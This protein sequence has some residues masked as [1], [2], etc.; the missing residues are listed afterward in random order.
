MK[1]SIE[2]LT[3]L[4]E[5]YCELEEVLN[6]KEFIEILDKDLMDK[7]SN[8]LIENNMLIHDNIN[9][10]YLCDL[11][12]QFNNDIGKHI[13]TKLLKMISK[14][15]I[16]N[17]LIVESNKWFNYIQKNSDKPGYLNTYSFNKVEKYNEIIIH[18]I[19]KYIE[20][21]L[22]I[23]WILRN[24]GN[25]NIKYDT[26]G[27]IIKEE[28]F[29]EY[30]EYND[31]FEFLKKINN[32]DNSFKHSYLNDAT[33]FFGKEKNCITVVTSK[34]E[35]INRNY[36]Q[37]IEIGEEIIYFLLDDIITQFN[38]FFKYA[39]TNINKIISEIEVY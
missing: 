30:E 18:D 29:A 13:N 32:I 10:G 17:E 5:K 20:V 6:L 12:V 28:S 22:E 11:G 26:L 1:N 19:K 16:T 31:Y 38:D 21:L 27:K 4:H 35:K 37:N 24:Y 39:V 9:F 34:K 33:S 2:Y 3:Q 23:D 7:K 15:N 8:V 14:I 25:N 36:E